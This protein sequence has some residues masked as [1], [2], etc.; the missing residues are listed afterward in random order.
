MSGE[1]HG[2][3]NGIF[4]A[5][6]AIVAVKVFGAPATTPNLAAQAG[7]Y[8]TTT[9]SE[10]PTANPKP[11]SNPDKPASPKPKPEPKPKPISPVY[12][13]VTPLY[14]GSKNPAVKPY[15]RD[16]KEVGCTGVANGDKLDKVTWNAAHTIFQFNSGLIEGSEKPKPVGPKTA[17]YIKIAKHFDDESCGANFKSSTNLD[18]CNRGGKN[19]SAPLGTVCLGQKF[20]DFPDHSTTPGC[21]S[22]GENL[23]DKWPALTREVDCEPRPGQIPGIYKEQVLI[24]DKYD[25]IPGR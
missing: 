2:F 20:S 18:H 21:P 13:T 5:I 3:R 23:G 1:R 14:L 8:P 11:T 9:A 16:L 19:A 7:D 22:Y 15:K 12:G 6:G 25:L 4:L 24:K 17:K 10:K